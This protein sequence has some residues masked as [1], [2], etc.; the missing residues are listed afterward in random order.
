MTNDQF[1]RISKDSHP[2]FF[3][4]H[5]RYNCLL[6]VDS[7]ASLCGV[8]LNTDALNIDAIYS[9]AQKCLSAPPGA[10]PVSFGPRAM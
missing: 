2:F 5:C 3:I 6:L 8:P 1:Y 9:G 7:V 10:S 4:F